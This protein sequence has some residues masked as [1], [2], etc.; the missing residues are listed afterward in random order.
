MKSTVIHRKCKSC[1]YY[2]G[3]NLYGKG[4][5]WCYWLGKIR[6]GYSEEC[7]DGYKERDK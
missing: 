3:H 7:E 2:E 4:H 1:G 5:G 6:Y